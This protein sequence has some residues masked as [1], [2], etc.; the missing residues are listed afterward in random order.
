[1]FSFKDK[2]EN[3]F[4]VAKVK[5]KKGKI[6]YATD[7]IEDVYESESET[8]DSDK[9]LEAIIEKYKKNKNK[10]KN[11]NIPKDFIKLEKGEQFIPVPDIRED[12]E[13]VYIYGSS[14]SGKSYFCK[15]YIEQYKKL[16]PQNECF[17]ISMKHEDMKL[18]KLCTRLDNEEL[19]EDKPNYAVFEDS[20]VIFDDC[21]SKTN[22][23]LYKTVQNLKNEILEFGRSSNIFCLITSHLACKGNESKTVLNEC[24]KLVLFLDRGCSQNNY[25]LENYFGLKR[26]EVEQYIGKNRDKKFKGSRWIVF[27]RLAPN[28]ILTQRIA[29]KI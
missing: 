15:E 4:P 24:H 26:K 13:I 25:L 18:D 27:S 17:L 12:R 23:E 3:W 6:L 10:S 14:G 19:I 2:G 21:D 5:N 11:E 22:K 16:F 7:N 8:Q 1:M 29:Y 9:E 20:L 28:Y